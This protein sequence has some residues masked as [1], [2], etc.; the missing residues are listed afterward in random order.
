MIYKKYDLEEIEING[1]QFSAIVE[2]SFCHVD[3][4]EIHDWIEIMDWTP[5][6]MAKNSPRQMPGNSDLQK[7]LAPFAFAAV[8]AD[9][10]SPTDADC[11]ADAKDEH[12]LR[13][14]KLDADKAWRRRV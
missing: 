5:N 4:I 11:R 14:L 9:E 3:G 1:R 12:A 2:M 6:A 7:L 10:N 8:E 13:L